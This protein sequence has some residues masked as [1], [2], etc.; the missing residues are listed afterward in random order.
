[1][2]KAYCEVFIFRIFQLKVI[3][4]QKLRDSWLKNVPV[5]AKIIR[6][7]AIFVSEWRV[8]FFFFGVEIPEVFSLLNFFEISHQL[9]AAVIKII[10]FH[11]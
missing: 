7:S 2:G 4:Y 6:E 10:V 11:F 5:P 9:I 8:V 3:T 1:M